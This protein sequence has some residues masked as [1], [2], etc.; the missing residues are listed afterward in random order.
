MASNDDI[1]EAQVKADHDA[2]A[3]ELERSL[4][5]KR[6]PVLPPP[7][8]ADIRRGLH[9]TVCL[10][11]GHLFFEPIPPR[12]GPEYHHNP[13]SPFLGL[14]AA[15]ERGKGTSRV[16]CKSSLPAVKVPPPD[17]DPLDYR[18]L[19]GEWLFWYDVASRY[20]KRV[21]AADREDL[22]HNLIIVLY[23]QRQKDGK[24]LP[25]LRAYKIASLTVALYWRKE[26][27]RQTRVCLKSGYPTEPDYKGCNFSHRPDSCNE[28]CYLALRPIQSL[29]TVTT[30]AD[31]NEAELLETIA[32]DDAI[33]LPAWLDAR[34]W[35][36]AAPY[37]LVDIARKR[38]KGT[39]LSHA[40]RL[41]LSKWRKR[42]QKSLF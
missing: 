5:R 8:K 9:F 6:Y 33:D 40:D 11:C 42:A 17:P 18:K 13:G 7:K 27:R 2:R 39:P 41:Y 36:A 19:S 12:A 23:S 4:P 31:G 28:C 37:R 32:D 3:A 15:C 29:D 20:S 26:S 14:C 34:T 22:L 10:K 30:D 16:R 21:P 35:I 38:G 1:I 24:P 25:E